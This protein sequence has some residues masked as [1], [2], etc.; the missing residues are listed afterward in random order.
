MNLEQELHTQHVIVVDPGQHQVRIDKYLCDK[1]EKTTRNKIQNTLKAG[2]VKVDGKVV[3]ANHKVKPGEKISVLLAN[4]LSTKDW[5]KAEKIDFEI[6]HEDDDLMV[7]NKP[8][9]LVVHPGVGNY[10]GTLVNGLMYH[11]ENHVLPVMEGN[12]ED[13]PGL[14][15]RIDKDTSGLLVIA[16]N[17]ASMAFL[18][19]QFFDHTIDR[20]YVALVWGNFDEPKG[21]IDCNIGRHPKDRTKHQAYPLGDVGKRAVT[22]YEV[23]E[24]MY[25]VSL[26][27]CKL[28]TG[29]T[30]Q[31]RVHMS[32][33]NH[34]LFNDA[35]YDGNVIRKGTV[36]TKYKQFVD[37]C[38]KICSRQALHAKSL[39]FEHPTTRERMR[40]DSPLPSDFSEMLDKWRAYLKNR[41][42]HE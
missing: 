4:P 3:K 26:I 29:R 1:L 36:F 35:R 33:K 8:A 17:E 11:F 19:K 14:V 38:F 27:K 42:K 6:V 18:S 20:E 28:E 24:D 21:S 39:E 40:F 13:R 10:S 41:K 5:L 9:G 37:N 34:A 30:H 22:H 12:E 15:H 31:I 16:K 2:A 23:I 7:V 25:Y 32:Y